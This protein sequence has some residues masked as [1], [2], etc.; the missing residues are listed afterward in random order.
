MA[1]VCKFTPL[2]FETPRALQIHSRSSSVNLLRWSLKL[3]YQNKQLDRA[4]RVNLL[5]WSL[6]PILE[7]NTNDYK[8]MCKFTPME[9][10]TAKGYFSIKG[11]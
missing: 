2:E 6:K 3:K 10:E 8:D 1:F 11:H 5:R 9:F 7:T 4:D